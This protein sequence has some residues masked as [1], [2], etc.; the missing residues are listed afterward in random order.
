LLDGIDALRARTR[1]FAV[2]VLQLV[3]TLPREPAADAIAR[4]L[5]RAGSG[6]SSNYHAA[7]RARSRAEFISKLS[8]G[9]EEAEESWHWLVTVQQTGLAAGPELEWLMNESCELRAIFAKSVSTARANERASKRRPRS[10][11]EFRND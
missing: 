11:D 9:V 3:R 4:Q 1:A 7:C 6:A 2:R 8:V 5:A 10:K